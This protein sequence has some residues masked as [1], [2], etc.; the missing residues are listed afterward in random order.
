MEVSF[1]T[2]SGGE[3]KRIDGCQLVRLIPCNESSTYNINL[4]N[5]FNGGDS[6]L[7]Y[8]MIDIGS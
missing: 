1:S 6:I 4:S 7:V 3:Q 2:E 8:E 5:P